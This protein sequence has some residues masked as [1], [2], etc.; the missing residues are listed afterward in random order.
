MERTRRLDFLT[1]FLVSFSLILLE[2]GYTR[3]YSWKVFYYFSY[4]I[5]GLALLG[6][7]VGS[8]LVARCSQFIRDHYAETLGWVL[9]GA[10]LTVGLGYLANL[11]LPINASMMWAGWTEVGK[12]ALAAGG[13]FLPFALVGVVIAALF[14]HRAGQAHWLYFYD[15]IGAATACVGAVLL[16]R[17]LTPPGSIF[18]GA[19]LL[20]TAGLLWL[21]RTST[22]LPVGW[23]V[24]IPVILAILTLFPGTLPDPI[25]DWAKHFSSLQRRG[26]APIYTK[27]HPVFRL[28]V[29]RPESLDV[30]TPEN[31]PEVRP[32]THDGLLGSAFFHYEGDPGSLDWIEDSSLIYPYALAP[33]RPR[34]LV[35]GAAGGREVLAG[36]HFG[37]S[38]VT[39]VE[40][41]PTYRTLLTGRFR[42]FTGGFVD[43]PRI[44]Y[45]TAEGRSYLARTDRK[46][47]L[48]YFVA[49]DSYAARATATSGGFILSESYLYTT[50]A[51]E[52]TLG[53]LTEDGILAMQ[54]GEFRFESAPKRTPRYLVTARRVLES[55]GR[56]SFPRQVIVT[57]S[58]GHQNLS[59]VNILV[60][61]RPFSA[62]DFETL[63]KRKHDADDLYHAPWSSRGPGTA[64]EK[65]VTK[66][67]EEL[68]AFLAEHEYLLHAVRDGSPY[69]WHFRSFLDILSE[70]VTPS[71]ESMHPEQGQGERVL[72]SLLGASVILGVVCLPWFLPGFLRTTLSPG[73]K[74]AATLYF[75]L[76]G[77]GFMMFEVTLVQQ[78]VLYLGYPTHS[79]TITLAGL[80]GATGLG[81][82]LTRRLFSVPLR[83]SLAVGFL[84]LLLL[85]ALLGIPSIKGAWLS[86]TFALRVTVASLCVIPIGLALGVF[87]PAGLG[88]LERHARPSG[89]A[90][91]WG[92]SVN[93]LFSV[94]GSVLGTILVMSYGF[95]GTL[96]V[97]FLLYLGA[98]FC[99]T[100]TEV[101]P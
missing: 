78:L 74:T 90:I 23:L 28:D 36:L 30:S 71:G 9:T 87:L 75:A 42:D 95:S 88:W 31:W 67:G 68:D 46:F 47:D 34:V 72:L 58:Q 56:D 92:W 98:A 25:T 69:F 10:G 96:A 54:F 99:L 84:G 7:S 43:S 65:V 50:E 5:L 19:T 44:T 17:L 91:A 39:A 80:L 24:P 70:P 2:V 15:M 53:H 26:E 52:E 35:V 14:A 27:W 60:R 64:V 66:S 8:G 18:L 21:T 82:L 76:I 57:R 77:A 86:G 11:Y 81:S 41:H 59:T 16:L 3:I 4:F 51:L 40:L 73:R 79:L 62:N 85:S 12:L 83:V 38:Q 101:R 29:V 55:P 49:P 1:I 94:I 100:L 22:I 61:K 48:I 63:R 37:A 20:T 89:P 45:L 6:I 13:V 93:G 97:A 32:V 33:E